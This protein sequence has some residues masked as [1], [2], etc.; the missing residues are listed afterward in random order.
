MRTLASRLGLPAAFAL[1]LALLAGCGGGASSPAAA[2]GGN[3]GEVPLGASA[4]PSNGF[5]HGHDDPLY[6]VGDCFNPDSPDTVPCQ[7][8]Y[9]KVVALVPL[10][11]AA[12]GTC[13][14]SSNG[15]HMDDAGNKATYCLAYVR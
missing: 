2:P 3:H 14:P 10:G 7:G 4:S 8:A 6:A 1:A 5:G 9:F 15:P 13:P 11:S 12:S